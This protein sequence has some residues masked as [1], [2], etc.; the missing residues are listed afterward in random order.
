[1][2]TYTE[3]MESSANPE[4]PQLHVGHPSEFMK[5]RPPDPVVGSRPHGRRSKEYL[6]SVSSRRASSF[7][8]PEVQ[9]VDESNHCR[10]ESSQVRGGQRV[11]PHILIILVWQ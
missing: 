5:P 9:R 7:S 6:F 8:T 1:M 4:G 2:P 11:N 3:S 10:H